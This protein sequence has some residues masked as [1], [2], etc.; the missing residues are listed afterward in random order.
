MRKDHK[1]DDDNDDDDDDDDDDISTRLQARQQRVTGFLLR[2]V[3]K[4]SIA[5][6]RQEYK[7]DAFRYRVLSFAALYAVDLYNAWVIASAY[8]PFISCLIHYIQLVLLGAYIAEYDTS[9]GPRALQTYIEHQCRRYLQNT[10]SVPIAELSHWRLMSW[11]TRNDTIRA[12]A[13]TVSPD[14]L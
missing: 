7:R 10:N 11:A 5:L 8:A 13:T 14:Y 3:S 4:L 6:V 12:P 2:T 1:T 9:T